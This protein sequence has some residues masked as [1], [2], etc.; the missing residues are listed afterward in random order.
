MIQS[1]WI[2]ITSVLIATQSD[3][4]LFVTIR[5]SRIASALLDARMG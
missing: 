5:L 1:E 2:A 3:I 4:L